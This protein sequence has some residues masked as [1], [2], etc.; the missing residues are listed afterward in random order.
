MTPANRRGH[1]RKTRTQQHDS[2]YQLEEGEDRSGQQDARITDVDEGLTVRLGL[3]LGLGFKQLCVCVCM[4]VV[5]CWD[6]SLV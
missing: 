5:V 4:C 3:G 2:G 6:I 1:T